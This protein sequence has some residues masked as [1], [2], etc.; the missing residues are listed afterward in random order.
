MKLSPFAR[1]GLLLIFSPLVPWA[2]MWLVPSSVEGTGSWLVG[3]FAFGAQAWMTMIGI[4]ATVLIAL[5]AFL[6]LLRV[7]PILIAAVLVAAICVPAAFMLL[8]AWSMIVPVGA[9]LGALPAFVI[10]CL[11]TS[12]RVA[13]YDGS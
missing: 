8:G 3:T 2:V 4:S 5:A 11:D 12:D 1:F 9:L 13:G 7:G 10:A 6:G